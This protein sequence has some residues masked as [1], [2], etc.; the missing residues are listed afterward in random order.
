MRSISALSSRSCFKFS[1]FIYLSYKY[2]S[3]KSLQSH[4]Y[5]Q[6]LQYTC[7]NHFLHKYCTSGT[8]QKAKISQDAQNI[9][10]CNIRQISFVCV[11]LKEKK[12]KS[13][14]KY[15][16]FAS[17]D[18][19]AWQAKGKKRTKSIYKRALLMTA[20]LLPVHPHIQQENRKNVQHPTYTNPQLVACS[21]LGR[22]DLHTSPKRRIC[23]KFILVQE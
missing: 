13:P 23:S 16:D 10:C 1:Y 21:K 17:D 2:N 6:V 9:G 15:C 3:T 19:I 11:Y 4:F 14:S 5:M 20:E 8:Y 7:S 18:K 12:K 22:F